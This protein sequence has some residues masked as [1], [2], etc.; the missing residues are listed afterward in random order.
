MGTTD[1]PHELKVY[2]KHQ[3]IDVAS[4]IDVQIKRD[5]VNNEVDVELHGVFRQIQEALRYLQEVQMFERN[6]I[7]AGLRVTME[8]IRPV[9]R[10]TVLWCHEDAV[11][12]RWD[13][14]AVDGIGMLYWDETATANAY[15]L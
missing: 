10:G 15:R 8:N 6:G 13:G 11:A 1:N 12:V 2:L 4:R 3:L 9:M 14:A 7:K 5:K